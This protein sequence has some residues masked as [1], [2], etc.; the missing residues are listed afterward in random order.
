M[1]RKN[2]GQHKPRGGCD[3][4]LHEQAEQQQQNEH[5][6]AFGIPRREQPNTKCCEQMGGRGAEEA[7]QKHGAT[8][9]TTGQPKAHRH[10]QHGNHLDF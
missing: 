5:T 8:I 9:D 6:K 2:L 4:A 7:D 3:R 1:E 10:G